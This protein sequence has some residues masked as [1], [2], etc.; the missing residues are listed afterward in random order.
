MKQKWRK[1]EHTLSSMYT[2]F[3]GLFYVSETKPNLSKNPRKS[4]TISEF[5]CV[6]FER[7]QYFLQ[8][9]L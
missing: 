6:N 7:W 3:F 9:V 5:L 4:K 8:H 1:K 2:L